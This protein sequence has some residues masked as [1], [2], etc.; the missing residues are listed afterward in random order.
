MEPG[1]FFFSHSLL[2]SLCLPQLRLYQRARSTPRANVRHPNRR[3][4]LAEMISAALEERRKSSF[5]SHAHVRLRIFFS[6]PL[7]AR[8]NCW[9]PPREDHTQLQT[10]WA[11]LARVS[12][13]ARGK[14]KR[15]G[16]AFEC[17]RR[18][19]SRL[20]H[21]TAAFTIFPSSSFK[22]ISLFCDPP[23]RSGWN[24][25]ILICAHATRFMY[26]DAWLSCGALLVG[27]WKRFDACEICCTCLVVLM[28]D[29]IS[30]YCIYVWNRNFSLY[31]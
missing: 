31:I 2:F 10:I 16:E 17:C 15:G 21:A 30:A 27:W 1:L 25:T 6:R 4:S 23:P 14:R 22:L 18:W 29:L 24:A 7:S 12:Q 3:R 13:T 9:S 11:L 8:S 28:K 19:C 26:S 20:S 5:S